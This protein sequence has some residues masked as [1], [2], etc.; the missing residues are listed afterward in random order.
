MYNACNRIT[1]SKNRASVNTLTAA[2]SVNYVVVGSTGLAILYAQRL[3]DSFKNETN[4]PQVYVIT[5]GPDLTTNIDIEELD[6]NQLSEHTIF[7]SLSVNRLHFV[8]SNDLINS[9]LVL[10]NQ[11]FESYQP[12]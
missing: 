9:N 1:N 5:A 7:K 11:V 8:V 12:F 4:P 10:D 3:Y 2:A 6:Y